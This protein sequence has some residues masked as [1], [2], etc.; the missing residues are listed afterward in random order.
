MQRVYQKHFVVR[1]NDQISKTVNVLCVHWIPIHKGLV[2]IQQ[3]VLLDYGNVLTIQSD[4]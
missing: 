3:A 4:V 1:I 2:T